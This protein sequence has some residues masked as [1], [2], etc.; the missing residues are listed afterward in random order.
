MDWFKGQFTVNLSISEE[1]PWFLVDFP[2]NQSIETLKSG[3]S[4]AFVAPRSSHATGR[5]HPAAGPASGGPTCA[6][7]SG[8]AAGDAGRGGEW[9]QTRQGMIRIKRRWDWS[10]TRSW[11]MLF[12]EWENTS[13]QL[14]T[15]DTIVIFSNHL[16]M[17]K[18]NEKCVARNVSHCDSQ[19]AWLSQI[20]DQTSAVSIC[21][22][23]S[24]PLLAV[25]QL[26]CPE[27]S[28]S[29]RCGHQGLSGWVLPAPHGRDL[30]WPL[31]A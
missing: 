27:R 24:V 7:A 14:N 25:D 13:W 26:G 11:A 17:L 18:R 8:R 5:H 12:L 22:P 20:L 21:F 9:P 29:L 16:N 31:A 28:C 1:N 4:E 19:Q 2:F 6:G 23:P 10:G 3:P 30:W 15:I